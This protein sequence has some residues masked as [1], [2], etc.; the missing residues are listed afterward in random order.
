M[1]S[2][3]PE[4]WSWTS[5]LQYLSIPI[6][7]ALVGWGTNV[8]ALRMTF[9]PIEFWGLKLGPIKL[10][11]QGIIPAKAGSMAGKAVD[12]LTKNLLTLDNR[13][14]QIEPARAAEE[15]RPVIVNILWE[16][17]EGSMK[18][19]APDLWRKTP[20][21]LKRRI[22]AKAL[23][24][25][26]ILVERL[27]LKVKQDINELFDLRAMIVNELE[28]DKSLLNLIFYKVGEK[29]FKFIEFSGL[30]FGFI[31]GIFQ[32]LLW[33]FLQGEVYAYTILPLAGLAVGYLT[34]AVAIRLIFEPIRPKKVG[35]FIIQGLFIKRQRAVAASYSKIVATRILTAS[36][37]YAYMMDHHAHQ[38]VEHML[39]KELLVAMNEIT[40]IS[41]HFFQLANG[42]RILELIHHDISSQFMKRLPEIMHRMYPYLDEVLDVEYALR[43]RMQNLPPNSF[44][45]FL[46]PVFQED[47]WKL[48]AVG[49]ILGFLAG[50]GQLIIIFGGRGL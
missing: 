8:L 33:Y 1:A 27:M 25:S 36:K 44:L 28:S 2:L 7:S 39:G 38:R 3:L 19:H 11:W 46:R 12:L 4:V 49:A 15:I 30:Y 26:P 37:I 17:I 29:E 14:S 9:Y 20:N 42:Y 24:R 6:T 21:S 41:R 23:Y 10:G 48:V 13:F 40:G 47:E 43:S 50:C 5:L 34:N 18:R 35:P 45:S 31:F 32:M 16:I 22:Y